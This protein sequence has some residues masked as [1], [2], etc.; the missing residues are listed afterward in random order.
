MTR[1]EFSALAVSY[2][3]EV[4]AYARRLSRNLSDADDLTQDTYARAFQHW[5]ELRDRR[6]CRAWLFRIARNMY[7]DR[8]RAAAVHRELRLVNAADARLPEPWVS[9]ETVER[10]E[11]RQLDAA[12]ARLPDSQR[13]AVL[14]CDLWGFRYEEIAEIMRCPL[15]TVQSRIARG[16][17]ALAALITAELEA[18]SKIRGR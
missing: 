5:R 2:L 9:A 7:I 13:E 8:S 4:T 3:G 17:A 15:G 1:D 6:S 16:R 11:A 12:L 14:L 10:L 18:E